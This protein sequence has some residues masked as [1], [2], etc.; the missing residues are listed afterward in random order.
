MRLYAK[1]IRVK[2]F[3]KSFSMK[4]VSILLNGIIK[5]NPLVTDLVGEKTTKLDNRVIF[6][7]ECDELSCHIMDIRC[8][9]EDENGIIELKEF[10]MNDVKLKRGNTAKAYKEVEV[11][12]YDFNNPLARWLFVEDDTREDL[13]VETGKWIFEVPEDSLYSEINIDLE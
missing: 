6:F 12:D 2:L 8:M 1:F 7:G 9:I 4:K 11:Y 10:D 5:E 3:H 13:K